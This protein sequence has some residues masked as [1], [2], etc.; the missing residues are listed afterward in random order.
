ML[1]QALKKQEKQDKRRR[2]RNQAPPGFKGQTEN[3]KQVRIK[4]SFVREISKQDASEPIE[5]Q[6]QLCQQIKEET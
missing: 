2:G 4:Q 5:I 3:D 6:D 1:N